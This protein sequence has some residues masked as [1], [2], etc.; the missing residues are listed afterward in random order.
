M[1]Q[2]TDIKL[3]ITDVALE[4]F[5][6]FSLNLYIGAHELKLTTKPHIR[7]TLDSCV[8]IVLLDNI[9]LLAFWLPHPRISCLIYSSCSSGQSFASIF[10]HTTP[11]YV[12]LAVQ[13][14]VPVI[15]APEDFHLQITSWLAFT[16]HL[17]NANH[18][19]SRYIWRVKKKARLVAGFFV[20]LPCFN[21][22]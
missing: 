16:Y 9:G 20:L 10:L 1:P 13:S 17:I 7:A 5:T 8:N 11:H 15:K 18:D 21:G 14:E 12:A 3:S 4:Y 6:G 22:R 19:A 2:K